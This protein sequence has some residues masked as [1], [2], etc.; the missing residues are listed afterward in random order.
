MLQ[1]G[2]YKVMRWRSLSLAKVW[3][4]VCCSFWIIWI[5]WHTKDSLFSDRS[6]KTCFYCSFSLSSSY[7]SLSL[8]RL[9]QLQPGNSIFCWLCSLAF[10]KFHLPR[11]VT[12]EIQFALTLHFTVLWLD[13]LTTSWG[14]KMCKTSCKRLW[15]Y[16]ASSAA[17]NAVETF[18]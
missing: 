9:R 14:A 3:F 10:V 18:K 2:L 13:S 17:Q 16:A 1:I 12:N 11:L 15:D 5:F 8:G 6:R 4:R 7:L